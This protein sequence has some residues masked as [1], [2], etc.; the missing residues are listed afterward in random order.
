MALGEEKTIIIPFENENLSR[1][2]QSLN[3]FNL[4]ENHQQEVFSN[5]DVQQIIQSKIISQANFLAHLKSSIF[6]NRK[7]DEFLELLKIPDGELKSKLL[8]LES[9]EA[10]RLQKAYYAPRDGSDTAKA[11]HRFISLGIIDT[12][13]IDYQNRLYVV[14]FKKKEPY[15]YFNNLENLI[16]RYSSKN[17][18]KK[19]IASLKDQF[20]SQGET[21]RR[22]EVEIS[23]RFLTGYVYDKIEKKRKQAT[24]DMHGLCLNALQK[25]DPHSQN[26]FIKEEIYY[27]FNARYSKPNAFA[28]IGD[29]VLPASMPD[30]WEADLGEME[31]IY[32]YLHIVENDE[33]SGGFMGAVKHLRGSSMRMLRSNPDAPQYRM[34][35]AFSLFIL[36]AYTPD[37]LDEA[38]SE[39]YLGMEKL[40][41]DQKAFEEFLEFYK[42]AIGRHIEMAYDLKEVFA[43]AEQI[44]LLRKNIS[45]VTEFRKR[46]TEVEI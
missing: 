19:E 31:T 37:L 27:Y 26:L 21:G 45:W 24:L 16:A 41:L 40:D 35:K 12:Y 30:D 28:R 29:Q 34:L 17:S 42:E 1:P 7:Y 46:L 18:A 20:E 8:N 32:K 13:T 4:N 44:Y 22:T 43:D 9:N 5:K 6:Y 23:L 25:P 2:S 10:L 39:F 33:D 15:S 3:D 36:A 14:T 38:L 11:I